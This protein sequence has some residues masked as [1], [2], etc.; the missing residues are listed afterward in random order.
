MCSYAIRQWLPVGMLFTSNRCRIRLRVWIWY[1]LCCTVVHI[2]IFSIHGLHRV[3]AIV[4]ADVI[5]NAIVGLLSWDGR[6]KFGDSN[7]QSIN[8]KC[9]VLT[10]QVYLADTASLHHRTHLKCLSSWFRMCRKAWWNLVNDTATSP[11]SFDAL[12]AVNEAPVDRG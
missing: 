1:A 8:F 5:A 9:S 11:L 2:H 10:V 4:C 6:E 12:K 3:H 7:R